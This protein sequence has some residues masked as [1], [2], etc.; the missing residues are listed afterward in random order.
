MEI[1]AELQKKIFDLAIVIV[2]LAAGIDLWDLALSAS[3]F[4]ATTGNTSMLIL[5]IIYFLAGALLLFI[6]LKVILKI[7]PLKGQ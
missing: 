2:A 1:P 5:I 6:A 4:S 3:T 7:V